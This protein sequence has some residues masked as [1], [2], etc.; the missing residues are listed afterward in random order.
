MR[1]HIQVHF[2]DALFLH[3]EEVAKIDQNTKVTRSM[4]CISLC[5]FLSP[6]LRSSSSCCESSPPVNYS[7]LCQLVDERSLIQS[8]WRLDQ[9]LHTSQCDTWEYKS[10]GPEPDLTGIKPISS[11]LCRWNQFSRESI[12]INFNIDPLG[13]R[14]WLTLYSSAVIIL[15]VGI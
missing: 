15:T 12:K 10:Q 11:W 2:V 13:R 3:Q 4:T 5:F 6:W 8:E 1:L 9:S 14:V 7:A